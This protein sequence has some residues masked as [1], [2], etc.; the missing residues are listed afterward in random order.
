[1][2]AHLNPPEGR[3]SHPHKA[4]LGEKLCVIDGNEDRSFNE[5][6]LVLKM[7]NILLPG[8]LSHRGRISGRGPWD[9]GFDE[10]NYRT[11]KCAT[12]QKLNRITT[13]D[14]HN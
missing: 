2:R 12:Q 13:V 8:L 9:E 5:E 4:S 10:Q 1:M 3:T 6:V 14:N 11:Y 7:K